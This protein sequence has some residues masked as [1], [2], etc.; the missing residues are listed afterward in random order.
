MAFGTR[1][2]GLPTV[3]KL[4]RQACKLLQQFGPII[5]KVYAD[6][7]LLIAAIGVFMAACD[8]LVLQIDDAVESGV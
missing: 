7:P 6:K 3:K 5:Q 4:I 2:T 1:K 8:E